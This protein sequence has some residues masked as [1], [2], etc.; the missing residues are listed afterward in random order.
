MFDEFFYLNL[1]M[2]NVI[3]GGFCKCNMFIELTNMY[4]KMLWVGVRF[5]CF[6]FSKVF[7][8]CSSS[9]RLFEIGRVVYG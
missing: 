7:K 4:V 9:V 3:I 1:F 5:D 2:W 6:I 8:G